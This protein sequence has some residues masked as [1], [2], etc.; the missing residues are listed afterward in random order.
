MSKEKKQLCD[1][2]LVVIKNIKANNSKQE[3]VQSL[4]FH[5]Q[6]FGTIRLFV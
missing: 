2:E 5:S 1:Y 6:Q 4:N 3:D